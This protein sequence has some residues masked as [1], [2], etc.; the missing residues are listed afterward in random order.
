MLHPVYVKMCK[1]II[2]KIAYNS[3][4]FHVLFLQTEVLTKTMIRISRRMGANPG[5]KGDKYINTPIELVDLAGGDHS[6]ILSRRCLFL[7]IKP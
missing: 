4:N 2:T 7:S 1:I 5:Q 3:I 6:V